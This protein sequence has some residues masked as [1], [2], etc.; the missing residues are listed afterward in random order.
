[1]IGRHGLKPG[2]AGPPV[3]YEAIA[4]YPAK[5]TP[6]AE[7]RGASVHIPRIGCRPAGGTWERIEPLMVATLVVAG[8]PTTV[9]DSD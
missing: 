4:E 8:V 3:R 7:R 5:L 2:S 6:E 1:M 9:Y